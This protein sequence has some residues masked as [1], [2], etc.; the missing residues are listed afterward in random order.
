MKIVYTE[1]GDIMVILASDFDDTIYFPEDR[2][3]TIENAEAI[4]NFVSYGNT[5]C[6]ITGRT[7]SVLK[8]FLQE[9]EIPY[10]Y[11]ICEDGAKIFNSV[12]YCLDT[13]GL[14]EEESKKIVEIIKDTGFNYYLSDGYNQT[15]NYND[16]VKVVI[17][18]ENKD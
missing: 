6:I 1:S 7:Y 18:C 9:F 15:E 13:V 14:S 10:S 16:C 8:T 3:K 12:D 11:L 4:R 2:K 5:F 17:E